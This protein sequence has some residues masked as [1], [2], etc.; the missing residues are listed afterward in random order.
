MPG[1]GFEP[2][3]EVLQQAK[4]FQALDQASAIAYICKSILTVSS[5]LEF[6]LLNGFPFEVSIPYDFTVFS[7]SAA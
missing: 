1:V 3:I 7:M 2:T 5:L 4:A 6:G